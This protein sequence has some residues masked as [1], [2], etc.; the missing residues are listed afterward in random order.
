MEE[1]DP[2]VFWHWIGGCTFALELGIMSTGDILTVR[3]FHGG[4]HPRGR[5][6]QSKIGRT[7]ASYIQP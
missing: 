2:R 3:E 7:E 5:C 6:V 1:S 4:E